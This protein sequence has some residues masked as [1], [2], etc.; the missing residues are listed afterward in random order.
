MDK[1]Q[2]VLI[3]L[4][5]S[6]LTP[7]IGVDG[8]PLDLTRE[9]SILEVRFYNQLTF[10]SHVKD[11]AKRAA[12]KPT[13]VRQISH[14]L[15]SR[16]CCMLYNSQVRSLMEY[17]PLV[18]S[19]CPPSFLA[20]L[21]SVQNQA[22]RLVVF[23]LRENDRPVHFQSLQHRRDVAALCVFY[24]VHQQNSPHLATLR[25]QSEAPSTYNIRN[26]HG[27]CYELHVP[28]ARI[29]TFLRTFLP[30]YSRMWNQQLRETDLHILTSIQQFK[31]AVHLSRLQYDC[32]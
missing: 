20:L 23:K 14:L 1:I 28:F 8:K 30:K 4:R 3:S 27:R 17:S 19:S 18:W 13:C 2:V 9:I 6:P 29:E 11:V 15:D 24:K 32:G 12:R 22:R 26:N 10:T 7:S 16:G 21:D 5:Q 31:T 25:L